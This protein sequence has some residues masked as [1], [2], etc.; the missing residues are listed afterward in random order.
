MSNI[1]QVPRRF[2][3]RQFPGLDFRETFITIS[4]CV[5]L[6]LYLYYGKPG[7]FTKLFPAQ[8]Q[9]MEIR[10]AAMAAYI[11]SHLVS[12]VLLF[13][14]PILL[15]TLIFRDNP[16]NWGIRFTG[17]RKEFLIVVLMYLAFLPLLIWISSR[18]GFQA[19]Y[20]KLKIIKDNAQLFFLYQGAYLIK[21]LAWEFFFR[22]YLLFGFA[23]KYGEAAI[24]FTTMPFVIV[25]LG[26]PQGEIFGAI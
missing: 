13:F 22:G 12:F 25:H 11:Y 14:I 17:S 26:K 21:W 2:L 18:A 7:H 9:S 10:H 4:G 20:P 23:K 6:I 19:K 16:R 5:L 24:L 1:I 15:I 8:A 3:A